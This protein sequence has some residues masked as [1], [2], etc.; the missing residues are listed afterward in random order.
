MH[1][2]THARRHVCPLWFSGTTESTRV[3]ACVCARVRVRVRA[4]ADERVLCIYPR[5]L[6]DVQPNNFSGMVDTLVTCY[7]KKTKEERGC[8]S[9]CES[10]QVSESTRRRRPTQH[11]LASMCTH[12][13]HAYTHAR[14]PTRVPSVVLWDHREYACACVCVCVCACACA[15]ACMC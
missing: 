11:T 12:T 15:C 6:K 14:A 13:Q 9:E 4:Y 2:H 3:R 5:H 7:N 8:A 10:E 1:T